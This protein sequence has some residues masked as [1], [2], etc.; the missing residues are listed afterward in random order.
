MYEDNTYVRYGNEL[1]FF[2]ELHLFYND[3][4]HEIHLHVAPRI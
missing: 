2:C 4:S 3:G 1:C